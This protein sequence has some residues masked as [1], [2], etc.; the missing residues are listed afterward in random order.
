MNDKW[1][2]LK[3]SFILEYTEDYEKYYAFP[4]NTMNA[5]VYDASNNSQTDKTINYLSDLVFTE[6][7]LDKNSTPKAKYYFVINEYK[8]YIVSSK[9]FFEVTSSSGHLYTITSDKDF[10]DLF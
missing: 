8:Y 2:R 9:V 4:S 6:E 5:A 7:S 10:S 1:Y 3:S